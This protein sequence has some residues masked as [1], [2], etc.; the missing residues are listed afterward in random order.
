M[1]IMN[2]K[3]VLIFMFFICINLVSSFQFDNLKSFDKNVG[4]YGKIEI[5]NSVLGFEWWQLDKI[6]ELELKNNTDTCGSKCSAEKEIIMYQDGILIDDVKYETILKDGTRIEQPI[7]SSNFYIKTNE[8]EIILDDYEWQC[9]ERE[10]YNEANKTTSI[11]KYDCQNVKVGTHVENKPL[12]EKYNLGDE[13]KAGTYYVKHEGEKKPSRTADWKIKCQ[14]KWID[15]WMIWG[16]SSVGEGL[17]DY[18]DFE[19]NDEK[20]AG[21]MNLTPDDG[22][23]TFQTSSLNGN[24]GVFDLTHNMFISNSGTGT[25]FDFPVNTTFSFWANHTSG[26]MY[27]NRRSV[28]TGYFMFFNPLQIQALSDAALIT[29]RTSNQWE[30]YVIKRNDTHVSLWRNG[31]FVTSSTSNVILN[32]VNLA[33]GSGNRVGESDFEGEFDEFAIWNRSL[34]ATEIYEINNSR[35]FYDDLVGGFVTL[36]SPDDNQLFTTATI[37]FN[38][39]GTQVG[40]NIANS[41]LWIN[42]SGTFQIENYTIGLSGTSNETVWSQ[43]ISQGDGSYIWNCQFCDSDGDC[44]FAT[45]NR[46]VSVDTEAPTIIINGPIGTINYGYVE[47]NEILNWTIVDANLDSM[48]YDYNGT[49][50]T[51]YGADNTTIFILEENNYNLTFYANDSIGNENSNFTEWEYNI[52]EGDTTYE[53]EIVEGSLE[54]FQVNITTALTLSEASL[55]YNGTTY[56]S[57]IDFSGGIYTLSSSITIPLVTIDSIMFF[58]FNMTINGVEYSTPSKNQSVQDL[59]LSVCGGVSND[60]LLNI[61]L[62]DET[63]RETINGTIEISGGIISKTSGETVESISQ[64][65]TGIPSASICFSPVSS[66]NLYYL[67]AEIRYSSTNYA[68]EFYIIQK[69]DMGDYPLNLTLFDLDSNST[70]EFL[71]KYQGDDLIAVEGAVIQLLRKYLSDANYETVEAP[72]TS[73]TG[74]TVLHIDLDT[75]LYQAIVIKEGVVLDIFTNLVF[76]CESELSGQCTQALF[77]TIDPQNSVSVE[78]L[79]DFFVGV[80]EVN[81]TITTVFSIPSGTSSTV[82]I[83]ME[84][85]DMFGNSTLC[86]QTIFSTAGSIDCV[87]DETI[88]DSMVYLNVYKNGE[89]Q[90]QKA[91]FVAES[92]LVDWLGNNFFIVL[93]LFLSVI[94]MAVSSPEWIIIN[95]VV[96]FIFAGSVW[97]LNGLS[98]VTGIGSTIWLIVA[99]GILIYKMAKQEDR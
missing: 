14:G 66:Y 95:G 28:G 87:Y 78:V 99:A 7:R 77:G 35:L 38:C 90:I 47:K 56:T 42:N 48:W 25:I 73:N 45:E 88:G 19:N 26:S 49:N 69:A 2:K 57:N 43:T 94:G 62:V 32:N 50:V 6:A 85:R 46:T 40:A 13:V 41:S 18:W 52:F 34:S 89:L 10:I 27:W 80:S 91:Y 84:Q 98:F 12:W 33:I 1:E 55:I 11:E 31:V 16:G 30:N 74:N 5:R 3:F 67:D 96:V 37:E 60:T 22:Q 59:Q 53:N 44:G 23:V 97:L 63:T 4:E 9:K 20:V 75:N 21:V 68:S 39:S 36:N 82:S 8:E 29:S 51:V 71:V 54:N 93:I 83:Q 64:N 72:L 61:S 92:G 58:N 65:F 79:E 70:T 15:E 76:H 17:V 86:N 81:N 24:A